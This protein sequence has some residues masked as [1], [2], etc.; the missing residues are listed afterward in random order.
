MKR[1]ERIYVKTA[2]LMTSLLLVFL[3]GCNLNPEPKAPP[4][5]DDSSIDL[6]PEFSS[7]SIEAIRSV[8][9]STMNSA[10]AFYTIFAPPLTR[11]AAAPTSFT[12]G[13]PLVVDIFGNEVILETSEDAGVILFSGVITDKDANDADVQ[14]GII[15]IR[16]NKDASTFSYR[17]SLLVTDPSEVLQSGPTMSAYVVTEIPE[18]S[19]QADKSFLATFRSAAFIS[20]EGEIQYM[21][22]GELYSGPGDSEDWVV[23]FAQASFSSIDPTSLGISIPTLVD[24]NGLPVAD[25]DFQAARASLEASLPDMDAMVSDNGEPM[26]GYRVVTD[27]STSTRLFNST[28]AVPDTIGRYFMTDMAGSGQLADSAGNPISFEGTFNG[29][30][31]IA[32]RTLSNV[33]RLVSGLPVAAWRAGSLLIDSCAAKIA[34]EDDLTGVATLAELLANTP[35]LDFSLV[36]AETATAS[37][38]LVIPDAAAGKEFIDSVM[39]PKMYA[40]AMNEILKW[41]RVE[42][43]NYA[44]DTR[45]ELNTSILLNVPGY[46]EIPLYLCTFGYTVEKNDL[47]VYLFFPDPRSTDPT[48]A[49]PFRMYLRTKKNDAGNYTSEF[50]WASYDDGEIPEAPS[51]VRD[52]QSNYFFTVDAATG[53]SS[54]YVKGSTEDYASYGE[55]EILDEV[56]RYGTLKTASPDNLGGILENLVYADATGYYIHLDEEAGGFDDNG[57]NIGDFYIDSNYNYVSDFTAWPEAFTS[58]AEG[59]GGETELA[60][61][62]AYNLAD[63]IPAFNDPMFKLIWPIE[64]QNLLA[65]GE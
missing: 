61:M 43:A 60:L 51:G 56:N 28:E 64:W 57:T 48:T 42:T 29:D 63:N 9:P 18:T 10:E 31:F 65:A 26:L 36:P 50:A 4:S 54:Y 32:D 8:I 40:D 12:V 59:W 5:P 11:F 62:A 25:S 37:R 7:A 38:A 21:D 14:T 55:L 53:K 15:E 17:S 41:I 23:G 19:I 44:E 34:F 46:G 13:K 27:T 39:D 2:A 24:A 3:A 52:Y 35:A 58:L 1:R 49:N 16:Y 6:V 20:L 22:A 45:H 47:R 30:A 33:Q